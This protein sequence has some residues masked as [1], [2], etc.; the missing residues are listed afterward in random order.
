[1]PVL[2][3]LHDALD[4]QLASLESEVGTFLQQKSRILALPPSFQ[5]TRLLEEN[6]DIK[7]R[8]GALIANAQL[9]KTRLTDF[10]PFDFK[11]WS[12]A[13]ALTLNA[14]DMAQALA[15]LH[16]DLSAHKRSVDSA[17]G[18]SPASA[19]SS[20][21]KPASPSPSSPAS[22]LAQFG[23]AKAVGLVALGGVLY[24]WS[25]KR[26]A[27][28]FLPMLLNGC[29]TTTINCSRGDSVQKGNYGFEKVPNVKSC[30]VV[31]KKR[32]LIDKAQAET[33]K[34]VLESA[35]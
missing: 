30:N 26:Y 2:E 31:V 34:K 28:I 24:W 13:K 9:L 19:P 15:V 14:A 25:K 22:I 17:P 3:K 5:R 10:D 16:Q 1:M 29:T 6:A 20:F 8:S 27:V 32:G 33:I 11:N 35:E 12:S 21:A 23:G 4:K 18:S 7:S